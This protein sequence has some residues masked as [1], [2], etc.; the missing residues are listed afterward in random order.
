MDEEGLFGWEVPSVEILVPRNIIF[1]AQSFE[2][3][4]R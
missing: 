1:N 2:A 3:G 4:Q